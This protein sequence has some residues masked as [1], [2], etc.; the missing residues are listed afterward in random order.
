MAS[1]KPKWRS[2]KSIR[3][4]TRNYLIFIAGN[5]LP[6][7]LKLLSSCGMFIWMGN[8]TTW[9]NS[10]S[11][12]KPHNKL[13]S[14]KTCGIWYINLAGRLKTLIHNTRRR[15]DGR[16]SSTNSLSLLKARASEND[17][18]LNK[19]VNIIYLSASN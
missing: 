11:F 18:K 4:C 17:C 13:K 9:S 19:A 6:W 7:T 14:I 1:C 10:D 8:S 5:S 15:M 16:S 3:L 2:L 12:C